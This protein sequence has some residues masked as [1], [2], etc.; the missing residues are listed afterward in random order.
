MLCICFLPCV[1]SGEENNVGFVEGIWYSKTPVFE[2]IPTRIY[3]AFRNNTGE[4]L[5]AT[6]HFTDGERAIG[7]SHISA[8][9]GRLV[10]AWVDWKPTYGDHRITATIEDALIQVIGGETRPIHLASMTAENTLHVDRDTDTDGIGNEIDTDD[11]NDGVT[12]ID[13]TVRG[14]NPLTPNPKPDDTDTPILHPPE[15]DQDRAGRTPD[16]L[17]Q[18]VSNNVAKALL[19]SATHTLHETKASIDNYRAERDANASH[20]ETAETSSSTPDGITRTHI[21]THK[22]LFGTVAE[23]I[24]K[25][26][27][28]ILTMLLSASSRALNHPALIE[29]V[30]LLGILYLIYKIA[31]NYGGRPRF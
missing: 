3:V 15:S 8:L 12:D 31:R 28:F 5:T 14:T 2:D 23:K 1:V 27:T 20:E 7:T 4:D 13:E 25:F 10:E 17:E 24:Q 9:S 22:T 16:G 21:D 6:I 18:Y 11:D 19:Q 26:F 29:F 30:F